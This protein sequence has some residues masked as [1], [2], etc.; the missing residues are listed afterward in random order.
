MGTSASVLYANPDAVLLF[1]EGTGIEAEA[2]AMQ[3]PAVDMVRN[4]REHEIRRL[5][6]TRGPVLPH[7]LV[8]RA[9]AA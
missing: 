9:D 3:H 5:A 6:E 8:I 7:Q 1:L 4:A 2:W